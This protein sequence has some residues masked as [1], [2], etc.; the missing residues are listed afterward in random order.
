M[1]RSPADDL[2]ATDF[3]REA[4]YE[5]ARERGLSI[6]AWPS[7]ADADTLLDWL[8]ARA[9]DRDVATVLERARIRVGYRGPAPARVAF[10]GEMRAIDDPNRVARDFE[11]GLA[12]A[13]AENGFPPY[14]KVTLTTGEAGTCFSVVLPS[15]WMRLVTDARARPLGYRESVASLTL[16]PARLDVTAPYAPHIAI[17][18]RALGLA[19]FGDA[20]FFRP[21]RLVS[22]RPLQRGAKAFKV[23]A[24]FASLIARIRMIECEWDS[25]LSVNVFFSGA[26]CPKEMKKLGLHI[27]GGE[28]L[29]TT[30]R[31]N[32]TSGAPFQADVVLSTPNELTCS[33]PSREALIL[34]CLEKMKVLTREA[35]PE[36]L[37]SLDPWTPSDERA[38]GFFAGAF[39]E[40]VKEGILSP[41]TSRAVTHPDH[42]AAGRRLIA[43]PLPREPGVWYGATD[44]FR[45]PARTLREGDLVSWRLQMIPLG[46]RIAR[47]A[48]LKGR[49]RVLERRGVVDFGGLRIGSA[50][51]RFFLLTRLPLDPKALAARLRLLAM[52]GHVVLVVPAGRSAGTDLAEVTLAHVAGPYGT[53]VGDAAR[54]LGLGDKVDP[55]HLAPAGTRLVVHLA[56]RRVWFDGVLIHPLREQ[57]YRLVEILAKLGGEAIGAKRL[58]EMLSGVNVEGATAQAKHG[59]KRAIA[60]SFARAGR[61]VPKDAWRMVESVRRGEVRMGV[62]VFVG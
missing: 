14:A 45:I 8:L 22:L 58:S 27:E 5:A 61:K 20:R 31:F 41:V 32:F 9:T 46:K 42:P 29:S 43:F 60:A 38:R 26:D 39:D 53:L 21:A 40:L 24:A 23:P 33:E 15:R 7:P 55:I 62:S 59:L 49:V 35:P 52:P 3:G 48:G 10:A 30:L 34:A 6:A 44:G 37:W 25:G 47:A 2:L 11:A 51:A 28:L 1:A 13:L 19:A 18:V 56:S 50:A 4:L 17:L 54:A 16:A 12:G 57:S 36:D